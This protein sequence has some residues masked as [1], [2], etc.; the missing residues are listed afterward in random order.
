MILSMHPF[1]VQ[2]VVEPNFSF[3]M[4]YCASFVGNFPT[5][6]EVEAGSQLAQILLDFVC[7]PAIG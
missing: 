6:K 4:A 7:I 3:V 5:K 2:V 1:P